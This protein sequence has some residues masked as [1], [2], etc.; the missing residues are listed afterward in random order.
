MGGN[1]KWFHIQNN[2]NRSYCNLSLILSKGKVGHYVS[3]ITTFGLFWNDRGINYRQFHPINN[4]MQ[5]HTQE[6]ERT[7]FCCFRLGLMSVFFRIRCPD[8]MN[9]DLNITLPKRTFCW[10]LFSSYCVRKFI[11]NV[12]EMPNIALTLF[13][14]SFIFHL[15]NFFK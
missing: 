13:V 9:I 4:K 2:D 15:L 3:S 5:Q 6:E 12:L 8:K 1:I 11:M 7:C 14:H 10:K